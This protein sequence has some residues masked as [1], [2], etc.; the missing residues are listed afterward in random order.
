MK[1][2]GKSDQ[3]LGYAEGNDD[4]RNPDQFFDD[5]PH[6]NHPPIRGSTF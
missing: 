5:F 2:G 1:D 4:G 3:D 6:P